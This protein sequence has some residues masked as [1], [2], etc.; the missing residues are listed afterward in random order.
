MKKIFILIFLILF[1]SSGCYD[2]IEINDIAVVSG[3]AIDYENDEFKVV[4]EILNTKNKDENN[5]EPKVY[6][7]EG[8]GKSI[9]EA[10]SK[11][12]FEISKTPYLAHLKTVIINEEIA[13]NH[14]D[15]IIDFLLRDNHIRDIFYL[16]MSKDINASTILKNDN[17]NNPVVSTAITDMVENTSYTNNI[18]TDLN[19]EKFTINLLD[20]RR[21]TYLTTITLQNGILKLG[22]LAIFNDY[23]LKTFLTEHESAIFRLID[24][25]SDEIHLKVN[26]PNDPKNF[27][28]LTTFASSKK[29]IEIENNLVKITPEIETRIIENHC[30]LNFREASS[31]EQVQNAL[32]QKMEIDIKLVM[33]KLITNHS[34]ILKIAELYYKKYKKDIDFTTLNYEYQ[35]TA[36]VNRNG[37]I[38]GVNK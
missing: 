4:F 26:C 28:I 16:V 29:D 6:F 12:T 37:L 13:K 1:C 30:G 25:S 23:N 38:Y 10:F 18:S 24:G 22:P 3:V 9:A 20:P 2:Y 17:L 21:D 35:V 11:T 27:I 15:K 34:D 36:I 5:S 32:K 31:Y 7:A 19:F 8:N 14:L 33:E